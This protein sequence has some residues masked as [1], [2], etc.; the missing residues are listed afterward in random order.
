MR[1]GEGAP[2]LCTHK[3]GEWHFVVLSFGVISFTDILI[4]SSCR[5]SVWGWAWDA[6]VATEK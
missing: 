5:E 6:I 2:P 1:V 3:Q 4:N